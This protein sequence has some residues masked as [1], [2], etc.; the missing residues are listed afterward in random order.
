MRCMARGPTGPQHAV[1]PGTHPA[2]APLLLWPHESHSHT[3]CMTRG[4]WVTQP[5][6]MYDTW[7]TQPY[8][9]YDTWIVG[10]RAMYDTWIGRGWLAGER[11]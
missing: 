2:P 7:V 9:M 8:S 3:A 11:K 5:Y 10:H 6:S 4:S 1:R